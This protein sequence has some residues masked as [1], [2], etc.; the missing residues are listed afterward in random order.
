MGQ[1]KAFVLLKNKPL[2][3]YVANAV[4][5]IVDSVVVVIRRE[6]E[7]KQYAKVLPRNVVVLKDA[8]P[9]QT[10]LIGIATAMN[11]LQKGY[12]VVLPC[13]APFVKPR[14]LEQLFREANGH[15]A[16]IPRWLDGSIEPL[17]AVYKV[18]AALRAAEDALKCKELK[19]EAMIKRLKDVRYVSI[20][21]L[22]QL[23]EQML[24]FF[25][26]NTPEDLEKAHRVLG[27][28]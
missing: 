12:C 11:F 5:R 21:K 14:V 17:Q 25:N 6:Y 27:S 19:N 1:N 9:G 8:H 13:D 18:D 15:D 10:P 2:I 20:D 22:R 4:L 23:D 16:A 7:E 26:I 3:Y 24:T 28:G